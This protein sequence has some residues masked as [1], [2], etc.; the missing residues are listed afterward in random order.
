MAKHLFG[1]LTINNQSN[2][3]YDLGRLGLKAARL[4]ANGNKILVT[5]SI[6]V[7]SSLP[8]GGAFV[9]QI[10]TNI[11]QHIPIVC[12]EQTSEHGQAVAEDCQQRSRRTMVDG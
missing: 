10:R 1:R 9:A 5:T 11:G 2:R 3:H 12:A 4:H 6:T 8:F 7:G